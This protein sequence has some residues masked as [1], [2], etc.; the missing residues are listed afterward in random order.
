MLVEGVH[1]ASADL[2]DLGKFNS[3]DF[4]TCEDAFINLLKQKYG[5]L[6]ELLAYIVCP[7]DISNE[8]EAAKE[9]HMF[10]LP[11]TGHASELD[12]HSVYRELKVFPIN[13]PSWVW[14]KSFDKA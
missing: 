5:V 8:F 6:K 2:K 10:E 7:D 1:W 9:W 14:I 4:N 13:S 3:D 12:N 11:L